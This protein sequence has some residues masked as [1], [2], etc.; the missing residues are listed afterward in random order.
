M[1]AGVYQAT[2]KDGSVYYRS[3]ITYHNKHISLGSFSTELEAH[4]AYCVAS[5]LL[6]GKD[7]FESALE[8]YVAAEHFLFQEKVYHYQSLSFDKFVCLMNFK[9]NQM[10]VGNP[11]YLRKKYFSYYFSPTEELK[12]DV[13]DLFYYSLHKIIKRQGHLFVNDYGMQVT[14]LS[15]YGIKSHAVCHKDYEFANGDET[16]Y[17]YQNIII[18]NR[19]FGVSSYQKNGKVR[20]RVK[21]HI[22]GNYTVGT[23]SSEE[24]AAIAYNKAV[25]L[26]KKAG[27]NKNYNEN[28]VD[29]LSASEYADLYLKVKISEKYIKYLETI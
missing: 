29:T 22:N 5:E 4:E 23:Y 18:I 7:N 10:Y 26:A 27:I 1:L 2:K 13:D 12:F 21:I 17:R 16:D 9:D 3:N 14:I 20:Y 24:K 19:Y 28:Y 8:K 6:F 11:I 25:D 15:R